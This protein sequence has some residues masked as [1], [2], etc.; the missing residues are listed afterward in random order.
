MHYEKPCLRREWTSPWDFL[1]TERVK[2]IHRRA[3]VLCLC[4]FFEDCLHVFL[5]KVFCTRLYLRIPKEWNVS[6]NIKTHCYFNHHKVSHNYLCS[7]SS[8]VSH[9]TLNK[10]Q[11]KTLRVAL[12]HGSQSSVVTCFC[13][14][15][16]STCRSIISMK[17]FFSSI[18]AGQAWITQIVLFAFLFWNLVSSDKITQIVTFFIIK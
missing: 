12:K 4:N 5:I 11:L 8:S 6:I 7:K 17:C 16:S 18:F 1:S 15:I 10:L 13:H 2:R 3:K 14:F 9:I